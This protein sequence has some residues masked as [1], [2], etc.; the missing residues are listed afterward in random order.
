MKRM[1]YMNGICKNE[2]V[3]GAVLASQTGKISA[4]LPNCIIERRPGEDC[5]LVVENDHYVVKRIKSVSEIENDEKYIYI[6]RGDSELLDLVRK[7]IR[8]ECPKVRILIEEYTYAF[9]DDQKEVTVEYEMEPSTKMT[10][11]M[12]RQLVSGDGDKVQSAISKRWNWILKDFWVIVGIG[13]MAEFGFFAVGHILGILE[14]YD[15]NLWAFFEY[16][17][18]R[19]KR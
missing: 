9:E 12:W 8:E 1:I 16:Y 15:T 3:Q 10:N 18:M 11:S 4:H 14:V 13:L 7:R 6:C 19:L 17:L 2:L 5:H